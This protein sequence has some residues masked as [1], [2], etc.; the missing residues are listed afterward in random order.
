MLLDGHRATSTMVFVHL[1]NLPSLCFLRYL[2]PSLFGLRS[3]R[4]VQDMPASVSSGTDTAVTNIAGKPK[5]CAC[6]LDHISRHHLLQSS[7][8]PAHYWDTL[9]TSSG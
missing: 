7:L 5:P 1:V 4:M 9:A 3:L 6:G 8:V 2:T